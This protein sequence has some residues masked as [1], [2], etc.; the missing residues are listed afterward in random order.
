M[1]AQACRDGLRVWTIRQKP[2]RAP[3]RGACTR[4]KGGLL[5]LGKPSR[6]PPPPQ[7]P[8]IPGGLQ[9]LAREDPLVRIVAD[10]LLHQLDQLHVRVRDEALQARAWQRRGPASSGA[11]TDSSAGAR[12]A[13]GRAL[14]DK[15]CTHA[16]LWT[17]PRRTNAQTRLR[18]CVRIL[19]CMRV[20][21]RVVH[22]SATDDS[23]SRT[24]SDHGY[25]TPVIVCGTRH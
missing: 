23:T 1:G 11:W 2:G 16:V 18:V 25:A 5:G 14:R 9:R 15:P 17:L 8:Q 6:W 13:R 7:P 21:L 10:Q 3:E 4:W 19:V 20:H 22:A 24:R 12:A